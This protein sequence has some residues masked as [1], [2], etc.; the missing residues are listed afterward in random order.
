MTFLFTQIWIYKLA[1]RSMSR[2]VLA[3]AS[4]LRSK[5]RTLSRASRP[6]SRIKKVSHRTSSIWLAKGKLLQDGRTL[7]DYNIK[8]YSRWSIWSFLWE[9][10]RSLPRPRKD[11]NPRSWSQFE[12]VKAKIQNK[13]G[14]PHDA[15]R[16]FSVSE[17][18]KNYRML[19]DHA[20]QKELWVLRLN[21]IWFW[22][23]WKCKSQNSPRPAEIDLGWQAIEGW[24]HTF[25]LQYI[26]LYNFGYYR[27]SSGVHRIHYSIYFW[28]RLNSWKNIMFHQKCPSQTF[29]WDKTS[30][31]DIFVRKLICI[32]YNFLYHLLITINK[33]VYNLY[34]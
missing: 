6:R 14:M 22:D 24:A 10:I 5:L 12:N 4:P 19:S 11:H 17:Q 28:W 7:S 18:L 25:W 31:H 3:S 34:K 26:Q 30:C 27:P 20:I 13:E 33:L 29:R 15:Q 8:E 2:Y 16:F 9:V 1:C 32:Q 23:Y 21:N